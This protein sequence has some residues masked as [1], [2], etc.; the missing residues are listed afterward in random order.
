MLNAFKQWLELKSDGQNTNTRQWC[1]RRGFEEQRF[2]EMTK[3]RRQFKDL[4]DVN[5]PLLFICGKI[6]FMFILFSYFQ[7]CGL[8][9]NE[10]KNMDDMTSAE[11]AL[12][13][14]ELKLLRNMKKTHREEDTRKRKVLKKDMW[15]V[16][17]N[18]D[19]NDDSVDIRDVDFRL[20][21]NQ[22]QVK[23]KITFF[24]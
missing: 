12:R 19:A 1:K 4:L 6:K 10:E 14:G 11:R 15:E 18:L 16:E 22:Q 8:V 5:F 3:L 24:D 7:E 20:R 13:Y 9:K 17:D 23:V 21:H 2:Y